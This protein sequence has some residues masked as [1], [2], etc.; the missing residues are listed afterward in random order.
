[1]PR[2]LKVIT[3][4]LV[5]SAA[6]SGQASVSGKA[7]LTDTLITRSQEW[8]DT[9]NKKDVKRMRAL[10]AEDVAD[11]LYGIGEEFGTVEHLLDDIARENFWNLSWSIKIVDPRVRVLGP[12]SALVAFRLIGDETNSKGGSRR[13]SAAYSLIFQREKRVWKVAHVHSS[14][15]AVPGSTSR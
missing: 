14:H 11:Q 10:H 5:A 13:Y 12:N 7:A 8:V 2:L 4:L 6:G 3:V 1:M 15:G 9:W